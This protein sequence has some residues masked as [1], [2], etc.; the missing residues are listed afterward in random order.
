MFIS[1]KGLVKCR[2]SCKNT[3]RTR[4]HTQRE[5]QSHPTW[6]T[7]L[8]PTTWEIT[9]FPLLPMG[10]ITPNVCFKTTVSIQAAGALI[11]QMFSLTHGSSPATAIILT[12]YPCHHNTALYA[13]ND[14]ILN[15]IFP[16]RKNSQFVVKP[17]KNEVIQHLEMSVNNWKSLLQKHK[18]TKCLEWRAYKR[19]G[20]KVNTTGVS[21]FQRLFE[22]V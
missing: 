13:M 2:R 11:Q 22:H 21:I 8:L 14:C 7:L 19:S 1:S 20:P 12:V 15:C 9:L 10:F 16:S 6:N 4:T 18:L 5:K 17:T 3:R